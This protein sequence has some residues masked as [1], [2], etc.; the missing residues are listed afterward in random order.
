MWY[1]IHNLLSIYQP[2]IYRQ[3]GEASLNKGQFVVA[4][5]FPYIPIGY[6]YKRINIKPIV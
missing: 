3:S 4:C 6:V 1:K 5:H 2:I